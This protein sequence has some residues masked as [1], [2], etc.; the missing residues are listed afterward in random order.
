[1]FVLETNIKN[2]HTHT[3]MNNNQYFNEK[4]IYICRNEFLNTVI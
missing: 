1:M 4:N 2:T 3:H